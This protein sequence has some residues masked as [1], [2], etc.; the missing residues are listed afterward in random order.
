MLGVA[1]T[2]VEGALTKVQSVIEEEAKL[3]QSVQRDLEFITGEFQMMQS[4]LSVA[5]E[6]RV[7]NNV[8]RTWVRQVRDLAYDVEDCIEFVVHLDKKPA[9]LR[10]VLRVPPCMPVAALPLDEAVAEI[11]QLKARV[12]DV[13]QRNMR[14]SLLTDSGS[15]PVAQTQQPAAIAAGATAFDILEEVRETA[16][17]QRGLRDITELITNKDG[18]LLVISVWGTGGDLGTTSIIRKAYDDPEICQKFACRGWAKL[19]HPFNPH[20]FLR[21]L[22]TQFCR[23]SCKEQ[24]AILD[25]DVLTRIEAA[26]AATPGELIKEFAEQVNEERYL[27]VLEDLS[28]MVEWDSIRIYLPDRQNGSRVIV[29]TQQF[30]IASLC[31]GHP[32]RVSELKQ[33][34]ADHSV[35]V[36]FKKDEER[37]EQELQ[38]GEVQEERVSHRPGRAKKSH[39]LARLKFRNANLISKRTSKWE[40]A[41]TWK[42]NFLLSGREADMDKLKWSIRRAFSSRAFQVITVWGVAGVGKSALVRSVY[43]SHILDGNIIGR[44]FGRYGWADVPHPFNLRDLFRTLLL[45]L[46]SDSPRAK[47]KAGSFGVLGVEDPIQECC[48]LIQEHQCLIVID[49]LQSAEEWDLI[50]AALTSGPSNS[51]GC[52]IIVISNDASVSTHC[53]KQGGSVRNVEG[54]NADEAF[55]L[56]EQVFMKAE[57]TALR[58]PGATELAKLI[59]K[60]CGGLPKV[61]VTIATYLAA[62]KGKGIADWR[63]L[64]DHF[65]SELETNPRLLSAWPVFRLNSYFHTCPDSRKTYIFYLLVFPQE[66]SI[67]RRR[68]V[69]RWIAE[70]ISRDEG[71]LT[72]EGNGETFFS[73]L[74]IRLSIIQTPEIAT[75]YSGTR[76]AV[77]QVEG[78]VREYIISRPV[79]DNFVFALEGNCVIDSQRTGRHL[80]IGSSWDRDRAVFDSIDF[81]RLRSLT[82]FGKWESFFVSGKMRLLRVLDLEDA[83]DVTD[84]DLEPVAELL[85]RLKFLSLRGCSKVHR[86][87]GSLGDLRQLQ[88]LDVRYTSILTLPTTI[89]KLQ[90][91]QYLRAGAVP[92]DDNSAVSKDDVDERR[93]VSSFF[94]F[95]PGRRQLCYDRR[96]GVKVPRGGGGI[97]GRLTA[98]NTL[99][100][101]DVDVE[102]GEAILKELKKLT[103]LR[104]LGVSGINPGNSQVLWSAISCHG[105]LESLSVRLAKAGEQVCSDGKFSPPENLESLKLYYGCPVSRLPEWIKHLHNLRKLKLWRCRLESD[106]V[107]VLSELPKLDILRLCVERSET[108]SGGGELRFDEGF[109]GLKFLE[110]AGA[111][112]RVEFGSGGNYNLKV[113]QLGCCEPSSVQISGLQHLLGL[114]QVS[115]K[116][117]CDDQLK[118]H[119]QQQLDSHQNKPVLKV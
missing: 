6:E 25:V 42:K 11:K 86:L 51:R 58:L 41:R 21:G 77:C 90:K 103:Q 56:F 65:M 29:S 54:L 55:G 107:H 4:F 116:G 82:V 92:L 24:R 110:L 101:I 5:D 39:L 57:N 31:V 93:S 108:E 111:L 87:P 73:E 98:L 35:C 64:N 15:K 96:Y 22:L 74:V 38:D 71:G 12:E 72:A 23:N 97:I 17:R 95:C 102:G 62:S 18:G 13:S 60:K 112:T 83:P 119:I 36:F 45:D 109:F 99:G 10:R 113:L 52:T 84:D 9:W 89:V 69:R 105:H 104:K 75:M 78:F 28:T 66:H 33:F 48:R 67:R 16:R 34:S 14:Y 76:M 100:V 81:S 47:K 19:T 43:Y 50:K 85:P 7:G 117:S 27:V 115:L 70:G 106:D 68:L 32:Y 20:E 30:E 49:G 44:C 61:I 114:V 94:K 37:E 3:W 1:K 88:T 46:C 91:L 40:A 26:A 2:V 63:Y 80:A 118:E 59:L 8:V 53:S 79:E